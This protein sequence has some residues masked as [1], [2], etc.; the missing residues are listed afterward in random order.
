MVGD[1]RDR[2]KRRCAQSLNRPRVSKQ[3][4]CL[5]CARS[6]LKCDLVTPTCGRCFGR[7]SVCEY[8][9]H[10]SESALSS[11]DLQDSPFVKRSSATDF[12][13]PLR[14]T[15]GYRSRSGSG[16]TV[17]HSGS[18]LGLYQ[19][20]RTSS[21]SVDHPSS[22]GTFGGYSA[23]ATTYAAD[24]VEPTMMSR[25]D[26]DFTQLSGSDGYFSTLSISGDFEPYPTTFPNYGGNPYQQSEL[27][28]TATPTYT[29]SS[30]P[31]YSSRHARANSGYSGYPAAYP[32]SG[33]SIHSPLYPESMYVSPATYAPH[34]GGP[35]GSR[36][37]NQPLYSTYPAVA[38]S[39]I[40]GPGSYTSPSTS[41]ASTHGHASQSHPD[42][43]YQS[44]SSP[45][46][47]VRT[48]ATYP[49]RRSR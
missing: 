20:R 8:P 23:S 10:A 47:K 15:S 48:S 4:A 38:P 39:Y 14:S 31:Q 27:I 26:D 6:K 5:F 16:S 46:S 41:M 43:R 9:S 18:D 2:H 7:G 21:S 30:G 42:P 1:L 28:P 36:A 12:L 22:P 34:G 40:S 19:G 32:S 37:L 45:N 44:S 3:K 24:I 29:G 13:S 25:P 35:L 49:P 33:G 11:P 17:S